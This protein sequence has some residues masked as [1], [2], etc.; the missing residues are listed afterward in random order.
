MAKWASSSFHMNWIIVCSP[1]MPSSWNKLIFRNKYWLKI[2]FSSN[3][4][5]SLLISSNESNSLRRYSLSNSFFHTIRFRF[6]SLLIRK[7]RLLC[8]SIAAFFRHMNRIRKTTFFFLFSLY[9]WIFWWKTRL[10]FPQNRNSWFSW[11]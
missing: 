5:F 7:K 2:R 9:A 4:N 8:H 3:R 1:K 6:I 11:F 10:T